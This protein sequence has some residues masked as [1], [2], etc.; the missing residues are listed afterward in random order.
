MADKKKTRRWVIRAIVSFLAI[1][2]LLTFFSNTIMN[3]T[4]P[5]VVAE[6][7][8]Q[9]NLSSTSTAKGR[10]ECSNK[11]EYK[12]PEELDGRKIKSINYEPYD[13]V[14]KNDLVIE[15]EPVEDTTDLDELIDTYESMSKE[16]EYDAR[17][18]K[19]DALKAYNDSLDSAKDSV[20]DA[21]EKIN[22]I[23]EQEIKDDNA[24]AVIDELT[25]SSEAL[26]AE[27]NA[28][29]TTVEEANIRITEI[30]LDIAK[31]DD[32]IEYLK[33]IPTTTPSD[34][35]DT[36]ETSETSTT[37]TSATEPTTTESEENKSITADLDTVEKCEAKKQELLDEKATLE[38]I[39]TDAQG[40]VST[41]TEKKAD[42]DKI[43]EE[44]KATL[45]EGSMSDS[46]LDMAEKELK[47]ANKSVSDAEK[48]LS[49]AKVKEGINAEKDADT[50]VATQKKLEKTKEKIDKMQASIDLVEILA[51]ETGNIND[52]IVGEGDKLQAGQV[53]F[54]IYP[55]Y[56]DMVC[57]VEFSFPTEQTRDFAVGKELTPDTSWIDTVT[58]ISIKP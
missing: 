10:I 50:K 3:A 54:S 39:I 46:S 19:E 6:Y 41:A 20:K 35:T 53:I 38:A 30:E 14:G 29:S 25:P 31:I 26:E 9:G 43:I 16:M 34:T 27:I 13:Y 48:N 32:K 45:Q 12:V 7:S 21:Q 18:P 40:R 44:A 33:L 23:K 36:S 22:K 5:K 57:T 51:P 15:L 1:M 47:N 28:A 52:I 58:I 55:D 4:I 49:D 17:T 11:T 56:S 42:V 24:Q 2:L 8:Q 37:E